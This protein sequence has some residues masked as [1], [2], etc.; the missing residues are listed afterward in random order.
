MELAD[1][2]VSHSRHGRRPPMLP[3]SPHQSLRVGTDVVDVRAVEASM[4]RF[5]AR[6]VERLFTPDEIAYCRESPAEA[7]GRFAARFAAKEA[8]L[9]VLRPV[10]WW[11]DWRRIEVVR[12]RGGWCHIRLHGE[13][14]AFAE[15][16]HVEIVSCSLSHEQSYATAVVLGMHSESPIEDRP[17]GDDH[18]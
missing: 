3:K 18:A 10:D 16:E 4:H 13:A 9:K 14:A 6:Y 2:G 8:A 15:R 7:G 11:P 1:S 5:G 17:S 12:D